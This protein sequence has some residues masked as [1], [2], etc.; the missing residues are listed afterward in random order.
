MTKFHVNPETGNVNR[1][2]AEVRC[3]FTNA[4]SETPKHFDNKEDAA[5]DSEKMLEA[6]YAG[7]STDMIANGYKNHVYDDVYGNYTYTDDRGV[8]VK[9]YI[10]DERNIYTREDMNK[11]YVRVGDAVWVTEY[12]NLDYDDEYRDNYEKITSGPL[13]ITKFLPNNKMS[14]SDGKEEHTVPS[15]DI[16]K[17]FAKSQPRSK[18]DLSSFTGTW[19]KVSSVKD[20]KKISEVLGNDYVSVTKAE[21]DKSVFVP[22]PNDYLQ[23]VSKL[24]N[25]VKPSKTFK[26]DGYKMFTYNAN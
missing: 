7:L 15:Y 14:V 23:T 25:T 21:N 5:K 11:N 1:C 6:K 24:S 13:K 20:K 17:I 16:G 18:T 4:R 10:F 26:Y 19:V 9:P 2:T 12:V 3:K 8:N 22:V